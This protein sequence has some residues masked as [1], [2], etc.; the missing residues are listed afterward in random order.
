M[1]HL[2][3]VIYRLLKDG[4]VYQEQ[5]ADYY[6]AADPARTQRRLVRGLEKLG[7]TV[8]LTPQEVA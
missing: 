4:V 2:L 5:G 7:Y 6:Q 3:L 1:H 8:Q